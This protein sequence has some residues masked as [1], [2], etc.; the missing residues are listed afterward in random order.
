[1]SISVASVAAQHCEQAE[2]SLEKGKGNWITCR[3]FDSLPCGVT[4][5]SR[6]VIASAW[7]VVL[8][9]ALVSSAALA[10]IWNDE[11]LAR[12]LGCVVLSVGS[13]GIIMDVPKW[14]K[15]RLLSS[16]ASTDFE[17]GLGNGADW[18]LAFRV[19]EVTLRVLSPL[20]PESLGLGQVLALSRNVLRADTMAEL[21]W[22][23]LLFAPS[24]CS[25]ATHCPTPPPGPTQSFFSSY[26][27]GQRHCLLLSG[28]VSNRAPLWR[29]DP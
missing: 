8:W 22:F 6:P 23:H 18:A 13:L 7:F 2:A 25:V 17:S 16:W 24:L 28:Q 19:P 4:L 15:K 5:L 12:W 9:S 3:R 1:M 29:F 26:I 11:A 21:W 20:K 27:S 14:Q 10:H